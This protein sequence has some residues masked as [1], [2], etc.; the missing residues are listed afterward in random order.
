MPLPLYFDYM[1]TTPMDPRVREAL[2][3]ACQGLVDMGNPSADFH[4]YNHAA[5]AA[6][7][8]GRAQVAELIHAA[9]ESVLFASG[10]TEANNL[11]IQGVAKAYQRQ[12]RHLITMST[13][14]KSV[15]EVMDALAREGFEV[16][17]LDPRPDGLLDLDQ[18]KAALRSDTILVSIMHVNNE[19][20]VI[21]NIPAIAEL[22]H[23]SGALLHV[24]A[25]Q[26]LG[27]VPVDVQ[28]WGADLASFSSHKVYGP[29]GIGALYLR[30]KPAI[31][32]QPLCYGGG[33]EHGL[34]PGTLPTHQV[35][36]FGEACAVAATRMTDDTQRIQGF[37]DFLW[38]GLQNGLPKIRLNGHAQ[39]RVPHNLNI[40]FE[41]VN[42]ESLMAVLQT[43]ACS[44]GSACN[45]ATMTPSHVL[46][47]LGLSRH[48]ADASLRFSMGRF[49]TH[50]EV[51][52]CLDAIIK[53]VT[54]LRQ[55]SPLWR[56]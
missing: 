53:G 14:H 17:R 54:S 37:Y 36:A 4:D 9:P 51:Q 20:G 34:R 7:A 32:L 12:G 33:Q 28:A 1:A 40:A 47:A 31:R 10:A 15:L 16:T 19:I 24:D 43:I 22:V 42:G 49:T 13:E 29:K 3:Q 45:A 26:S 30:A 48:L 55:L 52:Q 27:K 5:Q 46:L 2:L 38:G 6:I 8:K 41:G 56:G 23:A 44:R 25:A 18:L 39:Q 21:Q 35:V 50:D 11:A